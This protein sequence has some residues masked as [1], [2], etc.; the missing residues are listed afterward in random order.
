[1]QVGGLRTQA[2]VERELSNA[3][4]WLNNETTGGR[5][6]IARGTS[7]SGAWPGS[8]IPATPATEL[9][10]RKAK[11]AILTLRELALNAPV[12]CGAKL[13]AIKDAIWRAA[14]SQHIDV[15]NDAEAAAGAFLEL[16]MSRDE[17]EQ[18]WW[19]NEVLDRVERGFQGRP[20]V[21]EAHGSLLILIQLTECAE[22]FLVTHLTTVGDLMLDKL[23]SKETVVRAAAM[24]L[25]GQIASIAPVRFTNEYLVKTVDIFLKHQK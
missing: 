25:S 4:E 19:L 22:S 6:A 21:A 17:D 2:F 7:F 15:R 11:T 16:I 20:D 18:M 14:K 3:L 24:R 8:A 1:M 13:G 23:T 9:A 5:P 12:L 10:H